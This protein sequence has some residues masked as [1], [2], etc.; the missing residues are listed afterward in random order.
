MP[1]P[2][3]KKS[4]PTVRSSKTRARAAFTVFLLILAAALVI[5]LA[6]FLR[7]PEVIAEYRNRSNLV[8][9]SGQAQLLDSLTKA[10]MLPETVSTIRLDG[11]F[12]R[13]AGE[14]Y[15]TFTVDGVTAT[16]VEDDY[17]GSYQ[18]ATIASDGVTLKGS[19][20]VKLTMAD[21]KLDLTHAE[22]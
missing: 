10:P 1:R 18:I 5:L 9:E 11:I 8:V 17:I 14:N 21:N 2:R 22:E 3:K 16:M 7:H 12:V 13:R 4:F 15:A 19:D 20:T 6:T